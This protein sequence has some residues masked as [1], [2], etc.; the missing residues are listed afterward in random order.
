MVSVVNLCRHLFKTSTDVVLE[1]GCT[2]PAI[3]YNFGATGLYDGWYDWDV[4]FQLFPF[5]LGLQLS[6]FSY[7]L[8]GW[9]SWSLRVS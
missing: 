2:P 5:T 4:V 9:R 6:G 1:S 7:A 8:V 3:W